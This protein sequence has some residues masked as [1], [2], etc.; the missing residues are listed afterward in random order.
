MLPEF[1]SKNSINVPTATAKQVLKDMGIDLPAS[2]RDYN[3]FNQL[4][5]E[6]P[7]FEDKQIIEFFEKVTTKAAETVNK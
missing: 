2:V 4:L 6:L 5:K 3:T 1:F 7:D